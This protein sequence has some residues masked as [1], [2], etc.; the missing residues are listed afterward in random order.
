VTVDPIIPCSSTSAKRNALVVISPEL[1]I[2]NISSENTK[3]A[4]VVRIVII[5]KY[6]SAC[7]EIL[8]ICPL[9]DSTINKGERAPGAIEYRFRNL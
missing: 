5:P 4:K 2:E 1:K 6:L 3:R 9:A 8:E 7:L